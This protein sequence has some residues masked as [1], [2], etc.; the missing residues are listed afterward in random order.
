[1][2]GRIFWSATWAISR[3]DAHRPPAW[4][5]PTNRF[6]SIPYPPPKKNAGFCYAASG[7]RAGCR[8]LEGARNAYSGEFRE[9]TRQVIKASLLTIALRQAPFDRLRVNRLGLGFLVG[10]APFGLSLS[11]PGFLPEQPRRAGLGRYFR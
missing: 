3:D 5:I 8:K 7:L 4:L 9:A 11:K 6:L 1:M 2:S 10:L